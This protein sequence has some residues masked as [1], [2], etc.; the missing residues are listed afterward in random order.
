[1]KKKNFF[2]IVS[3]IIIFLL[4]VILIYS[5]RKPKTDILHTQEMEVSFKV[6]DE[7][8]IGINLDIA[9]LKFGTIRAGG[10]KERDITIINP[11][12]VSV[13]VDIDFKGKGMECV[14]IP[15]YSFV[16]KSKDKKKF[17]VTLNVP[18]NTELGNYTGVMKLVMERV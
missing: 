18:E 16:L 11:F 14:S 10:S 1:M 5:L 7:K 4:I 12:D 9:S 3:V 15:E 8:I 13:K 2:L 17:P 6:T